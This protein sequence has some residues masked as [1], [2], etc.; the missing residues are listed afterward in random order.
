MNTVKTIQLKV[1]N[2][3][4]TAKIGHRLP[5]IVNNLVAAP[6]LCDT[7]CEVKFTKTNVIVTKNMNIFKNLDVANYAFSIAFLFSKN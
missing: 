3:P 2:L 1:D 6:I 5:G 7:G 4:K